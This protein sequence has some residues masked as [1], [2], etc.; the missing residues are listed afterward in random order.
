MSKMVK[1]FS[2][3]RLGLEADN[4]RQVRE[5]FYAG[6]RA[7]LKSIDE[8]VPTWQERAE[9]HPHHQSG[10]ITHQ[11]IQARM[12]E[13]IDDLRETINDRKRRATLLDH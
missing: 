11:M 4:L 7:S 2:K 5:A 13:E 6:W 10:M 8:T 9:K 1:A 12:Q 3:S